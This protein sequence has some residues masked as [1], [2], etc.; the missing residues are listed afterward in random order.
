MLDPVCNTHV[1][2]KCMDFVVFKSNERSEDLY[3]FWRFFFGFLG[4]SLK[5]LE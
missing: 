4:K 5:M 1:M 2:E 3:R